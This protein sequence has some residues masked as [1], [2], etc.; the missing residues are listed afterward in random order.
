[1]FAENIVTPQDTYKVGRKNNPWGEIIDFMF[2][3]HTT[4]Y[5]NRQLMWTNVEMQ[6][7][8]AMS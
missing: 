2:F 3:T 7:S 6:A 8:R 1:M 4:V 5:I